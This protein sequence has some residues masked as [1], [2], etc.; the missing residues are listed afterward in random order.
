MQQAAALVNLTEG[1]RTEGCSRETLRRCLL[2]NPGLNHGAKNKPLV[3]SDEIARFRASRLDPN[4]VNNLRG[5]QAPPKVRS[6]IK[7]K[8]VAAPEP[9][10]FGAIKE[11]IAEEDLALKIEARRIRE[12]EL[13]PADGVKASFDACF[14]RIR[15]KAEI[16]ETWADDLA[17][18][19]GGDAGALR[20]VLKAKSR[21]F[22]AELS[23]AVAE[24]AGDDDE[25]EDEEAG[26]H[27][28]E[29][30]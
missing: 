16:I 6:K 17:A 13:L 15:R 30:D 12:G 22:Q 10:S 18:A 23:A 9:G 20:A 19:G 8:A 4:K 24:L 7:S 29:A 5:G 1:A 28:A 3:D 21:A 2:R 25:R 26:Q 11:K 27:D 14:R